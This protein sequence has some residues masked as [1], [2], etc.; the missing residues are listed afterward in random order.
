[1]P[2][3]F[4]SSA[5][6]SLTRGACPRRRYTVICRG[7]S[8]R[9][10]SRG[11]GVRREYE[12]S[13]QISSQR[14]GADLFHVWEDV[15][16]VPRTRARFSLHQIRALKLEGTEASKAASSGSASVPKLFPLCVPIG[17]LCVPAAQPATAGMESCA[18]VTWGGG[19]PSLYRFMARL[20]GLQNSLSH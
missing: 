2:P 9:R 10:P 20:S 19:R 14:G 13:P 11:R 8:R 17:P 15:T 1:M 4:T 12:P 7:Q 16:L 5:S 18:H 6:G 3:A